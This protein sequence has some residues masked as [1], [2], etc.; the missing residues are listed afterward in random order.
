MMMTFGWF[1]FFAG[2]MV[3]LGGSLAGCQA[4]EIHNLPLCSSVPD[5]FDDDWREESVGDGF[6]IRLPACFTKAP[7]GETPPSPHGR[8][9]WSCDAATADVIWGMW[10]ADS[11]GEPNQR[12]RVDLGGVSAMVDV[13]DDPERPRVLVWYQTGNVHEPIVVV[14][15]TNASD[16][17][18][19]TAIAH[20]GTRSGNS[21]P[22]R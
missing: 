1:A 18:L 20:S 4:G 12:C 19:I 13:R 17:A 14:S 7:A 15:S 3:V 6:S 8:D 11:F 2:P 5:E 10:T 22:D 21:G 16:V 9:R